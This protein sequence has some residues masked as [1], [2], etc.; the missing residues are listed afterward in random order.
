[1]ELSN[2]DKIETFFSI[3]DS[4][5]MCLGVAFRQSSIP[6]MTTLNFFSEAEGDTLRLVDLT[7]IVRSFCENGAQF[8]TLFP[9]VVS[10]YDDFPDWVVI[11]CVCLA[12]DNSEEID[13]GFVSTANRA[14]FRLA[15]SFSCLPRQHKGQTKGAFYL[16]TTSNAD[17]LRP[18]RL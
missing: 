15:I 11:A 6:K 1:M 14:S 16:N 12:C 9:E 3:S 17:F 13:P 18:A 4:W 5:Q 8:I 2:D 10:A 7:V